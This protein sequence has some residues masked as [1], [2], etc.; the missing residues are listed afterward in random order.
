MPL[1][2]SILLSVIQSPPEWKQNTPMTWQVREVVISTLHWTCPDHP[3]FRVIPFYKT[4][5]SFTCTRGNGGS[6]KSL[7]LSRAIYVVR[8]GA[9]IETQLLLMPPM[10]ALFL[11]QTPFPGIH[12]SLG[13]VLRSPS[14]LSAL[15]GNILHA[16][17]PRPC[18]LPVSIFKEESV[19]Q[20]V[21]GVHTSSTK[22]QSSGHRSQ[23]HF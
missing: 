4:I 9:E 1:G 13:T 17:L 23:P 19:W 18:L 22:R 6:E 7:P 21:S 16:K 15:A 20:P 11:V 10:P 12:R 5:I 14:P 8:T 3:L 2:V